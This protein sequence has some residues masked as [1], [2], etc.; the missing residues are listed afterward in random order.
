MSNDRPGLGAGQTLAF[1]PFLPTTLGTPSEGAQE[2]ADLV[3]ATVIQVGT[4]T[5]GLIEGGG[6]ILDYLR[7]GAEEARQ[8]VLAFSE[9]GMWVEPQQSFACE[10]GK[11]PTLDAVRE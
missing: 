10:A 1:F 4:T 9:L 7:P 3:G 2:L 11:N 6:L 5:P 8:L